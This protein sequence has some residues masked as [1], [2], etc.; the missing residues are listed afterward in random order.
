MKT[1]LF[2]SAIIGVLCIVQGNVAEAQIDTLQVAPSKPHSGQAITLTASGQW[3]N[4]YQNLTSG[5]NISGTT[6]TFNVSIT[7]G[8]LQVIT[9]WSASASI[10]TLPRGTYTIVV[11]LQQA[12]LG[13][14][15][16]KSFT[17]EVKPGKGN[18]S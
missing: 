9:S 1:I 14:I 8:L 2:A 7:D 15:T 11:Q 13:T 16:Q 5:T 17:V 4:A 6:I 12:P 10:G 18:G 3:G